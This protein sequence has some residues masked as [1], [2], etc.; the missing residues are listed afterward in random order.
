L[1]RVAIVAQ[2]PAS[3]EIL[4]RILTQAGYTCSTVADGESA[5]A[6]AVAQNPDAVLFDVGSYDHVL[7][8]V[9][10]IRETIN[11]PA[12]AIS[13]SDSLGG[14]P[15]H[16][17]DVDDFIFR[18]VNAAE[19]QLR[20]RRV[21][22]KASVQGDEVMR[23]GELTIDLAKCEVSVGGRAV[24]LTFKEY[25]LLKYLVSNQGRVCTRETLLDKVWGFDYYGGD[26]TVDVHIRRLRSKIEDAT[27][28]FIDTIRNIGYRFKTES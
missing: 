5:V 21:L 25:E 18:P 11:V 9:H 26:R 23:C 17:A 13:S 10:E 4:S 12:L 20:L 28:T 22:R 2:D 7:Q 24:V 1:P 16:F 14:M 19:L 15:G 27:H 6:S 3:A 8:I